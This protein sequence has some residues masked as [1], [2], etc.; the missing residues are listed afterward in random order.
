MMMSL[1]ICSMVLYN[2]QHPFSHT[3]LFSSVHPICLHLS[4]LPPSVQFASI[5][6]ICLHLSNLPPSVQFA[7][8]HLIFFCLSQPP[9]DHIISSFLQSSAEHTHVS[10]PRP[11][12]WPLSLWRED[13]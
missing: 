8:I 9:M 1:N 13:V 12:M 2:T 5:C 10:W 6:P 7:S 11:D 3:S 4:N